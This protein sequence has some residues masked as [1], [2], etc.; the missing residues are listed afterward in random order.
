MISSRIAGFHNLSRAGRLEKLVE[1]GLLSEREAAELALEA[2]PL[3]EL[4]DNLSENVI[5]AVAVPLGV[6]TN[7]TVDGQDVLVA[8][9]T[10][11]S[12]VIAAVSNGARACRELGGVFT[13]A[14]DPC[15]IA[16][17]QIT[18]LADL[19]AAKAKVESL[20]S[21][22]GKLCDA[23]DPMLVK[24]G[25]GFRDLEVR[26][27]GPFL[28]VHLIVDVR[29]AM[30]ANAVNTMAEALAPKL[31]GWTGGKVGLRILSNLADRRLV[32]ARAV[33]RAEEIGE[34]MVRGIVSAYEF[35]AHD[36]YR[37]A[38]HNKGIMNGISAVALATGNDT[39]AL[40][41]GAHAFASTKGNA[42]GYGPL[43]R[44][45]VTDDGD[46]W[47]EIELP[48]AVGIVGGATR[49]HPTAQKALKIMG[50]TRGERLGR[51]TAAVGLIQN[52]SALRALAGEGIQRGH[53]GLHAR[54]VA[55]VAGAKGAD[56]ER[57]AKLMIERLEIR[58]DV[59][60]ALLDEG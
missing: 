54:N 26:I 49:A 44:Y 8:M 19:A 10:E 28:V 5:G 6:A 22:I 16:Q 43:S 34:D 42:G 36:P 21:E 13:E 41:A 45:G 3:A 39:R 47:G 18:G 35:A 60:R 15:M 12:S 51:I 57:I 7:L 24:L 27:C 1:L 50:I 40:E 9:A 4:A 55:I 31:E 29:D 11:E 56:I 58:E 46:L 52:F 37:A 25:G 53:M 32:R 20:A 48:M 30:G 17:V 59:A 38:T 23:C 14:D 33:W 2:G